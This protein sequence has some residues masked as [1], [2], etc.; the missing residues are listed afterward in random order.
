MKAKKAMV[1][2][3]VSVFLMAGC[4]A[5]GDSEPVVP[6]QATETEAAGPGDESP[7]NLVQ[8]DT[9]PIGQ[10]GPAPKAYKDQKVY[11]GSAKTDC[12]QAR[13]A[14]DALASGKDDDSNHVE[15]HGTSV[16]GWECVFPMDT[17]IKE[18]AINMVCTKDSQKFLLRPGSLE[19]PAG[20]HVEPWD[21]IPDA[22][23]GA[24]PGYYFTTASRKHSCSI[25]N[26]EVG[27][28]NFNFTD[29]LPE[30][31]YMGAK[32]QPNAIVMKASGAPEFIGTG[33]P[34]HSLQS[35]GGEWNTDTAVLDYGH[36][37]IAEGI[38]CTTDEDRGVACTN[39]KHGFEVSSK[40][41][42]VY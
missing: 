10:C 40:K 31:E 14:L 24:G 23:A 4:A 30:V 34:G 18:L 35:A 9:L 39:G 36:V 27:C 37:L 2:L 29:T 11:K 8:Q 38:S 17:E 19:V 12:E 6:G 33:D 3:V 25:S 42:R 1:P 41:Y 22:E 21:F 20:Y 26:G 28:D 13:V 5:T 15:G 7:E 16:N 32:Q